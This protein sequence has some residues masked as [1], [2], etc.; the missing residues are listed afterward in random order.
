MFFFISN[1]IE[2]FI[3]EIYHSGHLERRKKISFYK[4]IDKTLFIFFWKAERRK[5]S[6]KFFPGTDA[7]PLSLSPSSFFV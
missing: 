7:L 3:I 2:N 5:E 1:C 4:G 6:E